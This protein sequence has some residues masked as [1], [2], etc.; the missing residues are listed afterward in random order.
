[1]DTRLGIVIIF[2][3]MMLAI[4]FEAYLAHVSRKEELELQKM[5]LQLQL[6]EAQQRNEGAVPE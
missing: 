6:L 3:V 2:A 4:G 1:M 5:Q